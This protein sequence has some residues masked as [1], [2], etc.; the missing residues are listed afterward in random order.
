MKEI[1]HIALAFVPVN[2]TEMLMHIVHSFLILCME[3]WGSFECE[4]LSHSIWC[5]REHTGFIQIVLNVNYKEHLA[6]TARGR[7]VEHFE[8]YL[9]L[10]HL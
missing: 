9:C 10:S 3:R 5:E 8:F 2:N 6:H 1:F 4:M 7:G